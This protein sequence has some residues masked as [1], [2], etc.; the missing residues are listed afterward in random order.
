M[1]SKGSESGEGVVSALAGPE[2]SPPPGHGLLPMGG[3]LGAVCA[4]WRVGIFLKGGSTVFL[5]L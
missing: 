4:A 5:G 2:H 1:A 3:E